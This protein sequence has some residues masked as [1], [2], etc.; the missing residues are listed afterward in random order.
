MSLSIAALIVLVLIVVWPTPAPRRRGTPLFRHTGHQWRRNYSRRAFLR[1]GMALGA[2]AVLAYSGADAALEHRHAELADPREG[3]LDEARRSLRAA[4]QEEAARRLRVESFAP[5]PSDRAAAMLKPW[6]ER[7][8]FLVWALIA[9]S[10]WLWRSSPFS[11]WGRAVFE[12]TCVGLPVLWT[13]QRVLGSNRPTSRGATPRWRLFA[14][15]HAASGHAFMAAIP[16]WVLA[17]R[18]PPQPRRR[19]LRLVCRAAGLLTGWSRL[20]DR[21][22]YPSQI[23]LGWVIAG[24]AVAALQ[25][26]AAGA[27][28]APQPAA[29]GGQEPLTRI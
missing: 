20:N 25:A 12:A 9:V 23:L 29:P 16:W 18:L 5:G 2:A 17:E 14:H 11:R 27:A 3:R 1:L 28:S 15:P 22:H 21:A 7:H 8:L 10:D 26:P 13:V 19:V 4:G 6:G 24:N